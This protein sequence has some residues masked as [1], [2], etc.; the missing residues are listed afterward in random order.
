MRGSIR[1]SREEHIIQNAQ[2][3]FF[4]KGFSNT[5]ISDICQ[6]SSCSRT[7]LYTYFESKE[8]LFLAVV[9]KAL[10]KF[11]YFFTEINIADLKGIKSVTKLA[12]AYLEFA[13]TFPKHYQ[14]IMDFQ[15]ILWSINQ[16]AITT[17]SHVAIKQSE[18]FNDVKNLAHLPFK[19]LTDVIRIGQEDESINNKVSSKQHMLNIWAYLKGNTDVY[20]IVERLEVK[21]ELLED[22]KKMVVKMIEAMLI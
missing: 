4:K 19:L 5:S 18:K 9:K 15:S 2:I 13:E 6:L 17:E 20:P 14:I 21:N 16:D 7:T 22:R 1:K 12:L 10:D 3:V 8:N 11:L